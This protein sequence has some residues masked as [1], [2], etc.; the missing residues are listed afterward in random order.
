M[1]AVLELRRNA[2]ACILITPSNCVYIMYVVHLKSEMKH[3]ENS[4]I[5][6]MLPV[7]K[8][9]EV[10]AWSTAPTYSVTY[11][12][13]KTDFPVFADENRKGRMENTDCSCSIYSKL[14]YFIKHLPASTSV[15][16]QVHTR[17][18]THIH[19]TVCT[20]ALVHRLCKIKIV[21]CTPYTVWVSKL[22]SAASLNPNRAVTSVQKQ[23]THVHLPDYQT[24][25]PHFQTSW[26]LWIALHHQHPFIFS[27]RQ[28]LVLIPSVGADKWLLRGVR[29]RKQS[30]SF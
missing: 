5:C 11:L 8:Y 21:H 20:H 19:R 25:P 10:T 27:I 24:S 2:M 12:P 18:H 16:S 23:K 28:G 13:L 7:K 4:W 6:I 17:A 1:Q 3:L 30:R 15:H 9:V 29:G 22:Q 26:V 14:H